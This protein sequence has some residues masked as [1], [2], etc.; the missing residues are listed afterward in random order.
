MENVFSLGFLLRLKLEDKT[1]ATL[2]TIAHNCRF[3]E[4]TFY[5][6]NMNQNCNQNFVS[7][8]RV[9]KKISSKI[10][11]NLA[12]FKSGSKFAT[13]KLV[14]FLSIHLDSSLFLS[15]LLCFVF[16]KILAQWLLLL[17]FSGSH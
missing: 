8:S 3:N 17:L 6:T 12:P 2:N 11:F 4:H 1:G 13:E 7:W 10:L 5:D 9:K 16:C 14:H 15:I